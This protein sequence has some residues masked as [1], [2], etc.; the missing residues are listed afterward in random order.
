M[1]PQPALNKWHST[2]AKGFRGKGACSPSGDV[3]SMRLADA[4]ALDV[5]ILT[6]SPSFT[7]LHD[8]LMT[9]QLFAI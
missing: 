8:S 7:A 3:G 9:K 1:A 5:S 6:P 4:P 2:A